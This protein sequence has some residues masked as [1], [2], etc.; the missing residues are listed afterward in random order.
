MLL[1]AAVSV[2]LVSSATFQWQPPLAPAPAVRP[3]LPALAARSRLRSALVRT[4]MFSEP[5]PEE[6]DD[7][8]FEDIVNDLTPLQLR[9]RKM[10]KLVFGVGVNA[11]TL[12]L[13]LIH[14]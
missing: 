1:V 3:A 9:L 13:S 6:P 11:V 14:I 8:V 5:P 12:L 7:N 4:A 10:P 2:A